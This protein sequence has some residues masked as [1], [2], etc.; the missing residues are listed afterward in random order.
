MQDLY[1]DYL[2]CLPTCRGVERTQFD[3]HR[4]RPY[5]GPVSVDGFQPGTMHEAASPW[6]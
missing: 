5:V 3:R 2:L 1:L 6:R 4:T